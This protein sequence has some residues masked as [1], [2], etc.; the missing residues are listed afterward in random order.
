V[1]FTCG[2]TVPCNSKS[3]YTQGLAAGAG[4]EYG[5]TTSLSAK[6]EYLWIGAGAGNTLKENIIRAG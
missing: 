5:F 3:A 2:T 6:A 1:G 4:V